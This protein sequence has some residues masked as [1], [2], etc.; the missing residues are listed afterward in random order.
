M[1]PAPAPAPVTPPPP[2]TPPPPTP[3]PAPAE[4]LSEGPAGLEALP[5]AEEEEEEDAPRGRS[6][7][8]P[9]RDPFRRRNTEARPGWE[10]TLPPAPLAPPWGD[11]VAGMPLPSTPVLNTHHSNAKTH[12]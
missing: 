8:G 11:P 3:L 5:A 6:L 10:A 4:V 12:A 7:W 2:A 9:P 1:N